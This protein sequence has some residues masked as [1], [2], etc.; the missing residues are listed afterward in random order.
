[1][2]FILRGLL[3]LKEKVGR[4]IILLGIMLTVC[5]VMISSFGI[6]SATKAAAVLARQK[7]GATVTVTQNIEKMM[8]KQRESSN[9]SG[10]SEKNR[11]K[12]ERVSVPLSYIDLL[13]NYGHV[14]GYL[15]SN[16]ASA[17]LDGTVAVGIDESSSTTE[18][19]NSN[20]NT[21]KMQNGEEG[22]GRLKMDTGDVTIKG[23]NDFKMTTE[24]V[25]GESTL[26]E[27]REINQEDLNKN[28]VMVEET[29]A[30]ENNLSVGSTLKLKNTSGDVE[31]ESEIIGIYKSYQTVD[32]RGFRNISMLPYNSIIAPYTLVTTIKNNGETDKVDS[33]KFYLDDPVN[34]DDFITY[35]EGTSI[36]LDTYTLDA[37][38]RQFESMMKPIENVASFSRTTIILVTVF[39]GLILALIIVLSIKD[40]INE[41]GILMSLGEKRVKIIGQFLVESIAALVIAIGISVLAGNA[42]SNKIG[43][44]LLTKE[45]SVEESSGKRVQGMGNRPTGGNIPMGGYF[46]GNNN[47]SEKI[48]EL[49]INIS[50]GEV[51]EMVGL[52]FA[53]VV[54][55]TIL[56][57]IMIMRYNPKK[58]LSKHS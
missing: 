1:M 48:E 34:V 53:V 45:L 24:Y 32:D 8:Q 31:V 46:S 43:D 10:S 3:T 54:I 57:S 7:L 15:A 6:Q 21:H 30:K 20:S 18:N 27:G 12:M 13:K 58:I 37:G 5:I 28:V 26:V 42:I 11:I 22:F 36:D 55:A 9:N 49:D 33:L 2:N 25:D 39:G 52:S 38:N 41:I 29:F 23:V 51:G 14:T 44:T 17:N 47:S 4:T 19:Q 56:P 16:S 40:R 50:S 35:G